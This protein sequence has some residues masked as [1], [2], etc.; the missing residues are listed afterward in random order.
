MCRSLSLVNAR[1]IYAQRAA[2]QGP[3]L[4][5]H[6]AEQLHSGETWRGRRHAHALFTQGRALDTWQ[7]MRGPATLEENVEKKEEK[8]KTL[9]FLKASHRCIWESEGKAA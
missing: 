8:K 6:R 5:R 3:T 9:A 1:T 4:A 7:S 2:A